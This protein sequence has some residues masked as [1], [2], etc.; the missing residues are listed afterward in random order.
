M[1]S[2]ASECLCLVL[3]GVICCCPLLD[4]WCWTKL[5]YAP[6][7]LQLSFGSLGRNSGG[8]GEVAESRPAL[9][10][11]LD[12]SPPGSSVHGILQARILI[13]VTMLSSRGSSR[14]RTWAW[15]S[16]TAGRFFT[17]ESPGKPGRN[18]LCHQ[19]CFSLQSPVRATSQEIILVKSLGL[20][21][22]VES[23]A[24]F[25]FPRKAPM[26]PQAFPLRAAAFHTKVPWGPAR[27]PG[28]FL[29]TP[30]PLSSLPTLK[31]L[32]KSVYFQLSDA[33]PGS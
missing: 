27:S 20:L 23:G 18:S 12:C 15:V 6:F 16:C 30:S 26:T 25:S 24:T 10:D 4:R 21:L 3:S 5:E 33:V 32:H 7:F 14:L 1:D 13:W 29:Y 2:A 31:S 22:M 8:G 19:F 17:T 11:P 28:R 9:R